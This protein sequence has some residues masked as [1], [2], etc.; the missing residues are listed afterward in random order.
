MS[1]LIMPKVFY[2]KSADFFFYG[3]L[4]YRRRYTIKWVSNDGF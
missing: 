1:L 4:F 2:K 3:Q